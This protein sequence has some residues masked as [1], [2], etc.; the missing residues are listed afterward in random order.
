VSQFPPPYSPPPDPNVYS[1]YQPGPDL[2][3]PARRASMLMFVMGALL[4]LGAVCCIGGGYML[5]RFMTEQP[6]L[7]SKMQLPPGATTERLQRE[8]IISGIM[9]FVFCVAM[10]VLGIFV[11]RGGTGSAVIASVTTCILILILLLNVFS[12]LLQA[13]GG[14]PELFAGVCMLLLPLAALGLLLVWLIQAA[15]A[16]PRIRLMQQQYASQMWQYQQQ[17]TASASYGGQTQ[18]QPPQP[19]PQSPPPND[20]SHSSQ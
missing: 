16:A 15:R 9:S 3:A 17:A 18:F 6:E 2:L 12:G 19:A 5:P 11:R 10:V 7:F 4:G 14:P 1:Y 20:S 13:R 8:A